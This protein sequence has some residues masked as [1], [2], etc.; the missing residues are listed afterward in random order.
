M[1]IKEAMEQVECS[2][3][4]GAL[5]DLI[6]V[7]NFSYVEAGRILGLNK[8]QVQYQYGKIVNHLMRQLHS[9]GISNLEEL[10]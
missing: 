10:L 6:S 3:T 5:L 7:H 9:K 4:E 8:R 2:E 1:I